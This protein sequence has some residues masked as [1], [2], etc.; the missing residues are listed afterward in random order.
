V[1]AR[2]VTDHE[3]ARLGDGVQR[4]A[5]DAEAGGVERVRKQTDRP[6]QLVLE[7][8]VEGGDGLLEG[9]LALRERL[10]VRRQPVQ[11]QQHPADP[12]PLARDL[13]ADLR[14]ELVGGDVD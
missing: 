10:S 1:A 5:V 7:A 6:A 13:L 14:P 3:L 8:C 4:V 12:C 2:Y 11:Q 9:C